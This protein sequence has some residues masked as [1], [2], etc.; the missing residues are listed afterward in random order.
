MS[1]IVPSSPNTP[2]FTLKHNIKDT[3]SKP[4]FIIP[5]SLGPVRPLTRSICPAGILG[6]WNVCRNAWTPDPL[7][8]SHSPGQ[9]R[10]TRSMARA[11]DGVSAMALG[12]MDRWEHLW[13]LIY[14]IYM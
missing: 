9:Q 7:L 2:R 1:V 12:E 6:V 4:L 10:V 14:G 11:T 3:S 8:Q 13:F 5:L